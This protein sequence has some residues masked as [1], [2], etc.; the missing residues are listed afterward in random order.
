MKHARLITII[1]VII[2]AAIYRILPHPANVT[3]VIAVALFSG[4][5]LSD[6]WQAILLP[7]VIMFLSDIFLGLHNTILFVY[8]AIALTVVIGFYLRKRPSSVINVFLATVL[9][10]ALFYIITNFGVWWVSDFY[11]PN[12]SGLTNSYL[13]GL[14]FLQKTLMGNLF[15]SFIIFAGFHFAEM[16]YP[17]IQSPTI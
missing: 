14:P 17:F 11:S 15:F 16:K 9:S 12:L 8:S 5:K 10:T 2:V 3:P 4:A 13:A 6:N 7:L 1:T